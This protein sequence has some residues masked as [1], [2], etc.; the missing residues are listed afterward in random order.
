MVVRMSASVPRHAPRPD[1]N[2]ELREQ[3]AA[4]A[5]RH[6]GYGAGMIHLELRQ[7]GLVVNSPATPALIRPAVP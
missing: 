1:H 7:K 3:I 4:L 5:H 2:V 6:G